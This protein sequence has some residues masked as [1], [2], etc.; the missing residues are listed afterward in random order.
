MQRDDSNTNGKK[1]TRKELRNEKTR[2][3]KPGLTTLDVCYLFGKWL[4]VGLVEWFK[5][6]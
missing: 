4:I 2:N 1:K 3:N 6:S 5:P